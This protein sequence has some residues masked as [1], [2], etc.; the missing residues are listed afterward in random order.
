MV[1]LRS[2]LYEDMALRQMG[3]GPYIHLRFLQPAK[4]AAA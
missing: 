1:E 2:L 4:F 3:V